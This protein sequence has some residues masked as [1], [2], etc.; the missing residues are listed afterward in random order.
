MLGST[1]RGPSPFLLIS[2][3]AFSALAIKVFM[4]DLVAVRGGS[5]APAV[6]AGTVALVAKCAYGLADPFSGGYLATWAEPAVG[7]IVVVER[8]GSE[9]RKAVKRV[10]E[11]G[12]AFLSARAGVLRGRGGEVGL[13]GRHLAGLAGDVFVPAGRV[14]LVGDASDVSYDSRDYG[15][16]PIETIIGKVVLYAAGKARPAAAAE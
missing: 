10:F 4:L 2:A 13:S 12:P 7:D 3:A 5:M 1:R 16:V 6:G 11:A 9:E 8:Y 15:S 14:F